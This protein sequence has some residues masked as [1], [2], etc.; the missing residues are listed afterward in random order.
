MSILET[1]CRNTQIIPAVL[2]HDRS[3]EAHGEP[4]LR[5]SATR[6]VFKGHNGSKTYLPAG[7]VGIHKL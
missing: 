4:S 1:L 7:Q 2:V 5:N 6:E 3:S